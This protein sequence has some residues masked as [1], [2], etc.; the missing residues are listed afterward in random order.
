MYLCPECNS[1]T[2]SNLSCDFCGAVIPKAFGVPVFCAYPIDEYFSLSEILQSA[3]KVRG[4]QF[5]QYDISDLLT[6]LNELPTD[7]SESEALNHIG[8][9]EEPFWFS[10]RFQEHQEFEQLTQ[11]LNFTDKNVLDIGA[12]YGSD[13]LRYLLKGARIT[14][15]EYSPSMFAIGKVIRPEFNWVGAS[16]DQLPFINSSFDYVV[17]HHSLHHHSN[18]LASLS[19]MLR[20]L[21]VG[22]TLITSGDPFVSHEIDETGQCEIFNDNPVVLAGINESV[23]SF[24][25]ITKFIRSHEFEIE[26]SLVVRESG[27]DSSRIVKYEDFSRNIPSSFSAGLVIKKLADASNLQNVKKSF[28]SIPLEEIISAINDS[29]ELFL[30]LHYLPREF[31]NLPIFSKNHTKFFLLNGWKMYRDNEIRTASN[32]LRYFALLEEDSHFMIRFHSKALSSQASFSLKVNGSEFP[33]SILKNKESFIV[34]S[35]GYIQKSIYGERICI[36]LNLQGETEITSLSDE[37]SVKIDVSELRVTGLT[38]AKKLLLSA[39][40]NKST[41]FLCIRKKL[42]LFKHFVFKSH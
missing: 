37:D 19:E 8:Y 38:E 23:L 1:Q 32:R 21:R 42:N 4:G 22:G 41:F 30:I 7:T 9:S 29:K 6:S 18:P 40:L 25:L 14:A 10:S 16:A 20:V 26:A 15:V 13:S 28:K 2:D 24:S 27:S 3:Y 11:M 33:F 39:S 17:A 5:S 34:T 36:E 12:G 31:F 35:R